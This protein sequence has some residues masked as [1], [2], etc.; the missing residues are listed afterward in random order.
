[1]QWIEWYLKRK[2]TKSE[3]HELSKEIDKWYPQLA[4]KKKEVEKLNVEEKIYDPTKV[5]KLIKPDFTR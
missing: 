5:P 3:W 1:M 4:E 2:L